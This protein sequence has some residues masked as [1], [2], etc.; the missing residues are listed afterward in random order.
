MEPSSDPFGSSEPPT[1]TPAPRDLG[2]LPNRPYRVADSDEPTPRASRA[3]RDSSID[4]PTQNTTFGP[5]FTSAIQQSRTE[6][7]AKR[8]PPSPL[9][10]SRLNPLAKRKQQTFQFSATITTITIKE[11]NT[12]LVLEAQDLLVKAY[13]AT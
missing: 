12:K 5:L 8:G 10:N 3:T 2:E 4:S 9:G 6:L 7:G 1:P 13:S 11:I